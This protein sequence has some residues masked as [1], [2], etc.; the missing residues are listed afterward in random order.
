MADLSKCQP[1]VVHR[2]SG[3]VRRVLT[4]A[5]GHGQRAGP[6]YIYTHL[7]GLIPVVQPGDQCGDQFRGKFVLELHFSLLLTARN[8]IPLPIAHRIFVN[9][10]VS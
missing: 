7:S 5:R 9:I 10:I 2:G 4:L 1:G 3:V 6:V 8:R